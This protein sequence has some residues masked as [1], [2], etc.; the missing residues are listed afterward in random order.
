MSKDPGEGGWVLRIGIERRLNLLFVL[1]FG[2]LTLLS[3]GFSTFYA[4][5]TVRTEMD[6]E[7]TQAV[8]S[9]RQIFLSEDFSSFP[10]KTYRDARYSSNRM[11]LM[12]LAEAFDLAYLYVLTTNSRGEF[13]FLYDT[14]TRTD[15]FLKVYR[16]PPEELKQAFSVGRMTHVRKKYTDEFGTFYSVFLPLGSAAEGGAV[17]GADY[18]ST[19]LQQLLQGLLWLFILGIAL[20]GSVGFWM[21]RSIRRNLVKPLIQINRAASEI[22]M[23]KLEAAFVIQNHDEIGELAENLLRMNQALRRMIERAEDTNRDLLS[24]LYHDSMTGLPNRQ[25]LLKDVAEMKN[26]VFILVNLDGFQEI[27]DFYGNEA[28]D[29]LIKET[30]DR[31]RALALGPRYRIYKMYADEFAVVVDDRLDLMGMEIM[32]IYLSEGLIEKPLLYHDSEIFINASLG[33]GKGGVYVESGMANWG[34]GLSNAEMALRKAKSLR[35]KFVIYDET[36]DLTSA[37]EVNVQ[38]SKKIREAV[39]ENRI[40]PYFQPIFN[41][42]NGQVEKY[43]CL[44]RLIQED[45]SAAEPSLFMEAARRA[46]LYRSITKAMMDK[47][48]EFF[49]N[50]PME[51]SINLCL[52][53][54]LDEKTQN[55]LRTKILENQAVAPRV[56]FELLETENMAKYREVV[57]FAREMKE[58]GC[59]IAIDDF[60]TGYSNF[61]HLI[62]LEVD[63]IKIDASIVRHIHEDRNAEVIARTIARFARELGIKTIAEHVHTKPV[64]EKQIELGIDFAQGFYFGEP[65]QK[66][67]I[68]GG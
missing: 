7:L 22:A 1:A 48:L 52:D 34:R 5:R 44:A 11:R 46:R 57:D 19:R 27:N 28:G 67:L 6:R 41:N 15:T 53:D 33:I 18:P 61:S 14:D 47:S 40:V 38:W 13:V 65:G 2:V 10:D 26:P 4:V 35:R 12:E 42:K 54:I 29:V 50:T 49:R 68:H 58:I 17:L 55:Y 62:H 63:Y 20:I 32:G 45:G 3:F 59:K 51:F 23:G 56:V 31:L 43:E 37:F 60:G 64:F 21:H 30:A 39:R 24:E 9:A 66:P 8:L 25:R 16:N 36:V